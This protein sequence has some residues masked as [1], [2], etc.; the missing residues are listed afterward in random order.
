[1]TVKTGPAKT[2]PAGPLATAML[3]VHEV[4]STDIFPG[5]LQKYAVPVM[6]NVIFCCIGNAG[7]KPSGGVLRGAGMGS[8]SQAQELVPHPV[9]GGWCISDYLTYDW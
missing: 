4:L 2:G 7:E 3:K 9:K 6:L 1:M 5:C 8:S